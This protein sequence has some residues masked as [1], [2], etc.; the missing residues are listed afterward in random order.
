C[1]RDPQPRIDA[2]VAPDRDL[3]FVD[4]IRDLAAAQVQTPEQQVRLAFVRRQVD[5]APELGD[6]FGVT[7][8]LEETPAALEVKYGLLALVALLRRRDRIVHARRGR[9]IQLGLDALEIQGNRTG[10]RLLLLKLDIRRRES[11]REVLFPLP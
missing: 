1:A 3:Q 7:L 4:R 10:A 11:L 2:V 5:G 9:G 8:G 6:R